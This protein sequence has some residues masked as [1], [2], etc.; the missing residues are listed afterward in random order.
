MLGLGIFRVGAP[1]DDMTWCWH[2]WRVERYIESVHDGY[3]DECWRTWIEAQLMA[4]FCRRDPWDCPA[5]KCQFGEWLPFDDGYEYRQC[6]PCEI[7]EFRR[8]PK[9]VRE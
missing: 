2:M 5:G 8:L 9:E 1:F 4:T 6:G 7:R 3:V